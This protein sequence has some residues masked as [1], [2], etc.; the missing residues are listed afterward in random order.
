MCTNLIH[1]LEEWR[2]KHGA[3]FERPRFILVHF[4]RNPNLKTEASLTINGFTINPSSEGK[5][6]G[7]IFDE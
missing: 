1:I 4:T 2:E 7:V 5:Y 6:L 3:Q